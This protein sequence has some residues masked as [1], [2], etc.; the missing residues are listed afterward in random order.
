MQYYASFEH[1]VSHS[2]FILGDSLWESGMEG[3]FYN[4]WHG[5]TFANQ[6]QHL[7][8]SNFIEIER[9]L[10][11]NSSF[12]ENMDNQNFAHVSAQYTT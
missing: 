2:F 4:S 10:N 12:V 5:K 6:Y 11:M 3:I 1:G 8:V 9:G 7:K